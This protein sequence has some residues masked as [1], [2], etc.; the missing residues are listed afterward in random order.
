MSGHARDGKPVWGIQA[1][2]TTTGRSRWF[3][4]G[5]QQDCGDR[6]EP[7][8]SLIGVRAPD[9]PI[10]PDPSTVCENSNF[11][12]TTMDDQGRIY[13]PTTSGLSRY[14]VREGAGS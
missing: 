10:V 8:F 9:S 2:D 6:L 14:S 5:K 3:V 4:A 11:A 7:L 1:L 12:G 13:M